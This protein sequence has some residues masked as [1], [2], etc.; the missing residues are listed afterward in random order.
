M[1]ISS[2][3]SEAQQDNVDPQTLFFPY[4]WDNDWNHR[5]APIFGDTVTKY[6]PGDTQ[7]EEVMRD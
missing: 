5:S 1:V 6:S 2:W 4:W 7:I 3:K